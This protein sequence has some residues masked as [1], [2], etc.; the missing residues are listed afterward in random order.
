MTQDSDAK[1]ALPPTARTSANLLAFPTLST[2]GE[3]D[4]RVLCGLNPRQLAPPIY[5]AF[6]ERHAD[7]A[8]RL[9]SLGKRVRIE[10]CPGRMFGAM[11]AVV[12]AS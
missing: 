3:A 10:F 12:H 11:G 9:A 8:N 1:A 4:V 7:S 6:R 5:T 2:N